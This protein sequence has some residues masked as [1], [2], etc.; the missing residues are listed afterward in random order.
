[1][2]DEKGIKEMFMNEL[3]MLRRRITDLEESENR[4]SLAEQALQKSE[5]RYHHIVEDQ[6]ELICRF[7]PGGILTFVNEAYCRFFDKTREELI[8]FSLFSLISDNDL[9]TVKKDVD[10][11]TFENPVSANEYRVILSSGEERWQQWINRAIFTK[12]GTFIEY[13]SVGRDVTENKRMEEELKKSHDILGQRVKER[14]AELELINKQ[15]MKETK[16]HK[17]AKEIVQE[18]EA[19]YRTIFETT[20]TATVILEKNMIISL[21]NTEFEKLSCYSKDEVEG[22]KYWTEFILEED[23]ESMKEYYELRRGNPK[24]VSRNHELCFTDRQGTIK[25]VFMTISLIP[26]TE[27]SVASF[28]DVTEHKRADEALKKREQELEIKSHY[29]EESNTA[30][31][32]LLRHQEDDKIEFQGNILANTKELIMPYID[33]LK[34]SRLAADQMAYLNILETNLSNIISP[35][36]RNMTLKHFNLTPREMQVANLVKNGKSSKEIA[37]LLNLST[38]AIEFHRENIRQ[39]L[40]LKNK[41]A[42]LQSYLLS[43]S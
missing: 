13:Q 40:G 23:V 8:G 4:L 34:K 6:T 43:H 32:V 25:H 39:K 10:A 29:L 17:R 11:L 30:L 42:N 38:R 37:Q 15:L 20:G 22:K 18:S 41:K 2:K 27:K 7:L 31:K 26:N 19:I 12:R 14:T 28:L 36:L 5:K 3:E 35:F 21:V 24:A 33:K 9:D 1:M 16:E